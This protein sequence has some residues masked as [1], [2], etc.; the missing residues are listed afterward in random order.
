MK[1]TGPIDALRFVINV[2]ISTNNIA[3]ML[4]LDMTDRNKNI[5]ETSS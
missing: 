4:G 5:R 2:L 1:E 3:F